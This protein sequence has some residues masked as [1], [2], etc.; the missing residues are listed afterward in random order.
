[1]TGMGRNTINDHLIVSSF[2]SSLLNQA[3]IVVCAIGLIGLVLLVRW[4]LT[5]AHAVRRGGGEDPES[6]GADA[7][8][9]RVS[10]EPVA[11]RVLRVGFGVLWIV[12][13]ALQAQSGM[14]LG[15]PSSVVAP[16]ESGNPAW[17]QHIVNFGLT[18]W[19][20]HP[21]S[22]AVA[23]VWIQ[24]GIGLWLVLVPA[25]R[26][27]RLGGVVSVGWACSVWVF[28]ET[29]GGLLAP[30]TS[31]MFG[32]PGAA[33]FYAVAGVLIALPMRPWQ[34]RLLGRRLL[35]GLGL[36]LV[37]MA[38]LQALPNAGFWTSG[39]SNALATMSTQMSQTPQ[40]GWLAGLL[41]SFASFDAANATA[42]TVVVVAALAAIGLALLSGRE[43]L[44]RP[45]LA[46]AFVLCLADWVLVQDL[47]VLG[48]VGTD[49]NSMIPT[50]L[51][52]TAGY[53]A[54]TR[55]A[56]AAATAP[57][58]AQRSPAPSLRHA[59]RI[60][61][62]ASA[63]AV[64]A[65]GAIPFAIATAEPNATTLLAQSID[66]SGDV[67]PGDVRP[68]DFVL[69]DQYGRRITLD[70]LRGKVLLVTYLDPVCT[71]DCPIIAQEFKQADRLLGSDARDVDLVAIDANPIYR[72]PSV[73]QAFD[74]DE[75]MAHLPN[76]LY[77]TGSLAQLRNVWN[78]FS[79]DVSIEPAG[80]MV[81]H[82]DGA[83]VLDATGR[84]RWVSNADPGPATTSTE[85]SFAVTLADAARSVLKDA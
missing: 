67:V 10:L 31:W 60:L 65:L 81:G 11:R 47:G 44:V 3:L 82:A 79:V 58:Q 19:Q 32:A 36:L 16:S 78:T 29:L 80:A 39:S 51:L 22:V 63:A 9:R 55:P 12:D 7:P 41:R 42:V 64:T 76:W 13:G 72:S 66:G 75:S 40:P 15:L 68:A 46:G 59:G 57:A 5:T 83:A 6:G 23:A 62:L 84:I 53:L 56:V 49:P 27:S 61:A 45:A 43:R 8:L 20:N 54:L 69:V 33:V 18:V 52:I 77:L 17:L 26:W 37:V 4:Q 85:S 24:L 30:G 71:T 74:R 14:P 2:H 34:D 21:V 73:L 70:G 28:G 35:A 1:M 48:G 38:V 25:G 50:L